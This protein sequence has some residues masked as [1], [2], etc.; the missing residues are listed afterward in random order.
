MVWD[1]RALRSWALVLGRRVIEWG[2]LKKLIEITSIGLIK[3][4]YASGC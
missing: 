2:L 4:V 3:L 1:W